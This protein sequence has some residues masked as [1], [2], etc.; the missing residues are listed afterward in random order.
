MMLTDEEIEELQ[1][2]EE[3]DSSDPENFMKFHDWPSENIL[4]QGKG[5]ITARLKE[6]QAKRDHERCHGPWSF[7][8]LRP[9]SRVIQ[10]A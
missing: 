7:T 10:N 3:P 1:M 5:I 4:I 6:L 8:W 9:V 2:F